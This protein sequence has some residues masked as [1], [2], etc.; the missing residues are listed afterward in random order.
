MTF[1]FLQRAAVGSSRSGRCP[2]EPVRVRAAFGRPAGVFG[3]R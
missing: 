2:A 1:V 3:S